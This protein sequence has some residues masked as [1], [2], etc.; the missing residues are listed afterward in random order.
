MTEQ[1]KNS[2]LGHVSLISALVVGLSTGPVMAEDKAPAARPNQ[3]ENIVVTARRREESLQVAPVAVSAFSSMQLIKA[4]ITDAGDVLKFTPGFTFN[5]NNNTQPNVFFREMGSDIFSITSDQAIGFFQDGVFLARSQAVNMQLFD[6]QRVE[7]VKGPQGLLYG[8][9]VAGGAVNFIPK[10]PTEDFEG[11]VTAGIGN[12]TATTIQGVIS[13][14]ISDGI[15]GRLSVSDQNHDGYAKNTFTGHDA[16]WKEAFSAR[17]QLSVKLSE[18]LDALFSVDGTRNR[19]G[20]AWVTNIIPNAH[21]QPFLQT[22]PRQ[23][24]NNLDPVDSESIFGGSAKINWKILGGTLS[25][26]TAVRDATFDMEANDG[27]SYVDFTQ[28]PRNADGSINIA[29]LRPITAKFNDDY[30]DNH[31]GEHV[32]TISEELRFSSDASKDFS[33]D[34]GAYYESDL[35]RRHEDEKYLFLFAPGSFFTFTGETFVATRLA[36]DTGSVFADGRYKILK[37]ITLQAGVRWVSD[38]KSMSTFHSCV[39]LCQTSSTLK[40][41]AGNTIPSFLAATSKS[42][43]AATPSAS[44]SYQL[45]DNIFGY[46]LYSSGF[47]SGGWNDIN[48]TSTAAFALTSYQPE[49][50]ANKEIGVKS[51]WFG[52]RLRVNVTGFLTDYTNLQT[53][54]Y[55]VITAGAPGVNVIS[56]AG[57]AQVKGIELEVVASPFEGL[58]LNFGGSNQIGKITSDLFDRATSQITFQPVTVNENGT[59]LRRTPHVSYNLA[60]SYSRP[61]SASMDGFV[62]IG[63]QY[64]GRYYWNNDK[65]P[66]LGPAVAA[67]AGQINAGFGLESTKNNWRVAV[68]GK[69]LGDKLIAAGQSYPFAGSFLQWYLPPRTYGV[70]VTK[71]F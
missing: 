68:W 50:S 58:L 44:L 38:K 42:W 18:N 33:Y 62:D 71:S 11:S 20:G 5:P 64:T 34:L 48:G 40:D 3:I 60:A 25:S 4:H 53:Q 22:N 55:L 49:K 57:T 14:P 47:K 45:N 35:G 70:T 31:K 26:Q 46:F 9:N 21:D 1:F 65:H 69:N 32:T 66:F 56:N 15:L 13:G 41:A 59:T 30:Y 19:G 24:P 54:Q 43:S 12:Y 51:D 52:K 10:K 8:K 37:D 63:Y 67:A 39:S 17:G 16:E 6:L 29:A 27:G 36:T 61:V 23:G 2:L 7:V 28:I